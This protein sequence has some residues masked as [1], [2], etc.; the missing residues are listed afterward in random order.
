MSKHTPG[1]WVVREAQSRNI[2]F[3][4]IEIFGGNPRWLEKVAVVYGSTNP[5]LDTMVG[6]KYAHSNARLIASSPDS[7]E[8]NRKFIAAANSIW[9]I[10]PYHD[11]DYIYDEMGG[12]L[13]LAYF[14]ARDAIAK[15]TGESA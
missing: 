7:H 5:M 11:D 12:D 6:A 4:E 14:A 15:A 1:P 8:A 9:G 10:K 3:I 2:N 13:S